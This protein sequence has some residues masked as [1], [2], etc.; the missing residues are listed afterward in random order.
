MSGLNVI[1][2]RP[3]AEVR[4]DCHALKAALSPWDPSVVRCAGH[5]TGQVGDCFL[6]PVPSHTGRATHSLLLAREIS[7]QL[8]R[9]DR[10][11]IIADILSEE[12]H[13]S[14]CE[15]EHSGDGTAGIDVKV[16][17]RDKTGLGLLV[18]NHSRM[19]AFLVDNVVDT[20]KTARA[21]MEAFPFDGIIAVGDTGAW[22][23]TETEQKENNQQP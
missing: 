12:P 19:P 5:I 6:V 21:C 20:G 14:L 22:R 13:R 16:V 8:R 3:Y 23:N 18:R 9:K 11:C 2:A 17:I 10:L 15:A 7:A 1:G 4:D